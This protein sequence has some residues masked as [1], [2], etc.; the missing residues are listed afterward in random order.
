MLA[1]IPVIM[2]GTRP[3]RSAMD[4]AM[5]PARIGIIILK[6]MVPICSIFHQKLPSGTTRP[7]EGSGV[8]PSERLT[9]MSRPPTTTKGII[10]ETP[11]IRAR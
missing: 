4:I 10:G 8:P 1:T 9:A 11:A 6:P 2:P 5:K 7:P 3:G